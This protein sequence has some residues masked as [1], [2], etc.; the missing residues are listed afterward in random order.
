MIVH[1]RQNYCNIKATV[2]YHHIQLISYFIL[3]H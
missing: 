1:Y 2:H 3:L